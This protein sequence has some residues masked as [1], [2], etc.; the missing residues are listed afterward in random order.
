MSLDIFKDMFLK[1][2]LDG[3]KIDREISAVNGEY[4]ISLTKDVR[5]MLGLLST[6]AKKGHVFGGFAVGSDETLR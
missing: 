1:P 6:I 5:R 2:Q 4:V 3:E